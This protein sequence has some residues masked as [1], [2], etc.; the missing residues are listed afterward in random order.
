MR[1]R[2]LNDRIENSRIADRQLAEHLAIQLNACGGEGGNETVVVHAALLEGSV[3]ARD[4]KRAEVTLLLPAI[5][6]RVAISAVNEF[7]G[8]AVNRSRAGAK[9]AGSSENS[10]A[11]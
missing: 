3:Q 5:A 7:E 6:I 4:P 1:P 8:L 11:F 9:S 10:F 2:H